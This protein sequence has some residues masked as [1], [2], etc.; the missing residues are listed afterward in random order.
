MHAAGEIHRFH[1][2]AAEAL[3]RIQEKSAGLHENSLGRDLHSVLALIRR[4]E[5]FE[6]DLVALE[7]QLQI[8]VE[9]SARLQVQYPGD[10]A[11]QIA[12][13][14]TVV[15]AAWNDLQERSAQRKEALLASCDLQKFLTQVRD[16]SI[17]A[18]GLRSAMLTE[19]RVRDA[20]SAQALKVEHEALKA[21]IEAREEL[22]QSAA[23]AG[24]AMVHGGHYAAKEI[25]DKYTALLN[26]RQ[27][28]HAAWQHKKVYLDQLID[29]HFFLRDAK[30]M[31]AISSSQEA[32]LAS[33][34]FGS[35]VEEVQA[36]VR[37]HE[38]FERL[39]RS[40]GEERE[41]DLKKHGEKLLKQGH[42]D[43]ER[44]AAR[45]ESALSRRE[46]VKELCYSRGR[47]LDEAL[48]YAQFV[49][50]VGEAESWIGEKAKKLAASVGKLGDGKYGGESEDSLEEK[51]KKLQKHQAFQAE[52]VA[53]SKG[54]EEIRKKGEKLIEGKHQAS[55]EI[56]A[57]LDNLLGLWRCL[58]QDSDN[59]GRGLEEAQDILEFNNQVEQVE[60]WIRN[61]EMLVQAGDLGRDYEHCQALIRKLEDATAAA[62]VEA[63]G[64]AASGPSVEKGESRLLVDEPRMRSLDALAD[65]LIRQGRSNTQAVHQRREDLNA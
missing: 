32:A 63:V 5:G 7:A 14:Q 46:K 19:E 28:L 48:L 62:V 59:C 18:S 4:H 52:L 1:R 38:A 45:L 33:M 53:N 36:Q 3:S 8:L 60:T 51:V 47:L 6:N 35:T 56:R 10:N 13:R 37:K 27:Q 57:Q 43:K 9:D 21:E 22:F 23:A 16:L 50:D 61:K 54:I 42:F 39:L 30:Q 49:R 24:E 64:P 15:V 55:R 17:W 44:I 65:R 34:D 25:E 11:N 31:D 58:Q 2:D 29:L 41:N 26:E 12:E 40:K 20:A